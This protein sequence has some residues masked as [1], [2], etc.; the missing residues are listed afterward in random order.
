MTIIKKFE[1]EIKIKK[2]SWKAKKVTLAI[3]FLFISLV[4]AEIWVANT[5][6]NFGQKFNNIKALEKTY[7]QE[8]QILENEI[9]TEASLQ[10]IASASAT[11]G[12]NFPKN[13]KYIR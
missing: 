2:S 9:S 11:L 1:P 7:T 5:M 10:S 8:N 13:I 4:I 12:L 6:A 3:V